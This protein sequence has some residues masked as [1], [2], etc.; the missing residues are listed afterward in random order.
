MKRT[1]ELDIT[2]PNCYKT[3]PHVG[4]TATGRMTFRDGK[5]VDDGER[6]YYCPVCEVGLMFKEL[7]ELG[8]T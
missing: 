7:V 3:M 8:I 1:P 5:W 2:C 6:E 4:Y